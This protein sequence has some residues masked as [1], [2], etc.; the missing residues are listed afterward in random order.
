MQLLSYL[1]FSYPGSLTLPNSTMCHQDRSRLPRVPPWCSHRLWCVRP[2][3]SSGKPGSPFY[4]KEP[5]LAGIRRASRGSS[6]K[7]AEM[8]IC[9]LR[10]VGTK[11]QHRAKRKK[12]TPNH[13]SEK[14]KKH[15][16]IKPHKVMARNFI[17][18]RSLAYNGFLVA[19]LFLLIHIR[20][21]YTEGSIYWRSYMHRS[22]IF[23]ASVPVMTFL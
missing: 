20:L 15:R 22:T 23:R 11:N 6:P 18:H 19:L 21:I 7:M 3:S 17:R 16:K 12:K 14:E 5:P 13:Q 8:L 4:R 10:L 2:E 9:H 1:L